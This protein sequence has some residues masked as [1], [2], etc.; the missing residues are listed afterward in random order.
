MEGRVKTTACPH[1]LLFFHCFL[2]LKEAEVFL[3]AIQSQY[4]T[5]IVTF[6]EMLVILVWDR[7]CILSEL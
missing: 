4:I 2:G 3:V 6:H 5:S 7:G 1:G